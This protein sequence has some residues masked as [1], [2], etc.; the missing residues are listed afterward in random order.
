MDLEINIST[1]E[2]QPETSHNLPILLSITHRTENNISITDHEVDPAILISSANKDDLYKKGF[3]ARRKK[4]DMGSL[5]F[6]N[7]SNNV[8]S[9]ESS[10]IGYINK[11]GDVNSPIQNNKTPTPV[12]S[13]ILKKSTSE[14]KGDNLLLHI[15]D[16]PNYPVSVSGR[17]GC[18]AGYSSITYIN[19]R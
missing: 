15:I 8:I 12:R 14:F 17:V 2:K 11:G 1:I 16:T 18:L 5:I 9:E 4:S 10:P 19:K 7:M 6:N 13:P 3:E